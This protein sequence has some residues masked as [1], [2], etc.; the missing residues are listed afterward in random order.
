[1]AVGVAIIGGG[2]GGLLMGARLRQAGIDDF[3]LIEKGGDVGGT[4]Y[5]NRYPG[6]ACDVESYIYLPLLEEI[7]Y[8]PKEKYSH[9]PEI[10]T[11]SWNIS[12]HFTLSY[13]AC[14]HP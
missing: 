11:S 6:A 12:R 8:V 7:G 13:S 14:R 2:F 9:A 4:W 10:F 1:D 5:W 3:L